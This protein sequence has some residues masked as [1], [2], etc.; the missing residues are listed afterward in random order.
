[1]VSYDIELD[2]GLTLDEARTLSALVGLEVDLAAHNNACA[3]GVISSER[4]DSAVRAIRQNYNILLA[5]ILK[6]EEDPSVRAENDRKS[7]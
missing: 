6:L 3:G 4:R 1:L 5:R 2:E 7:A